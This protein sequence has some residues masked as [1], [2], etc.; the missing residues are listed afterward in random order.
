M[1]NSTSKYPHV[2]SPIQV[3]G[4]YYK[5]R[6]CQSTPGAG[7]SGSENGHLTRRTFEYFRPVAIGGAAVVT[8]GNCSIDTN[9]CYDEGNQIDLSDDGVIRSLAKFHESC[10]KYGTIG[11]IEINHNGAT[12]GNV[13]GTKAG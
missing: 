8:V 1:G 7:G 6:L 2:F 3:R 13:P 4:A 11:Q 9:E 10:A 12:Q 5:N